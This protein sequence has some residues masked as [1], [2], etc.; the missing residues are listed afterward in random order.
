[1]VQLVDIFSKPETSLMAGVM[2]Y[3]HG[4]GLEYQPESLHYDVSRCIGMAHATFHAETRSN[5]QLY[6]HR[7]PL[8]I[9]YLEKLTEK[10]KQLFVI[11]NSP[12]E[13]VDKGMSYMVGAGWR[14]FFDVI[15][16]QAGKPHFFTNNGMPF[17][18]L[19]IT[20]N[21]TR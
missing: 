19:A 1:M 18:E 20:K 21:I 6:L 11:T 8:L 13:T 4:N 7:D 2:D 16:V 9:P 10:R 14:D 5:P 17:R 12:F 15:I 3:F